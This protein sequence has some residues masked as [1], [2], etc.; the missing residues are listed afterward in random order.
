MVRTPVRRGAARGAV[1]AAIALA[2]GPARAEP[3]HDTRAHPNRVGF[4][5]DVTLLA[6]FSGID[7]HS[8]S[9]CACGG[10]D[11]S[12]GRVPV[13]GLE[14]GVEVR[15]LMKPASSF[16]TVRGVWPSAFVRGFVAAGDRTEL[17][18]SLVVGGV[19]LDTRST[20]VVYAGYGARFPLDVTVWL[21]PRVA[22]PLRFGPLILHTSLASKGPDTT[23]Y[24]ATTANGLGLDAD[25]G[26]RFAF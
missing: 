4:A 2:V 8:G 26:L 23:P 24:I 25:L 19:I 16:D 15:A 18:A 10:V 12:Y 22:V 7:G 20:S 11:L 14:L 1:A 21:G 6:L 17:G 9:S 13:R 5:A 3:V